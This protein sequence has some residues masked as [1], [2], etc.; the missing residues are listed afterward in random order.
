MRVSRPRPPDECSGDE[1]RAD[2]CPEERVGVQR[3]RF[4]EEV[5]GLKQEVEERR[6]EEG[7][8]N[9]RDKERYGRDE[10]HGEDDHERDRMEKRVRVEREIPPREP[11][12]PEPAG[13]PDEACKPPRNK[14]AEEEKRNL[15][16]QGKV[17]RL[18]IDLLGLEHP[19]RQDRYGAEPPRRNSRK[20]GHHDQE[21][22]DGDPP[23]QRVPGSGEIN[24]HG[25][26][27]EG[28]HI[29]RRGEERSRFP[30]AD[31]PPEGR[32]QEDEAEESD[33]QF[34]CVAVEIFT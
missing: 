6:R 10:D 16:G 28:R 1:E 3:D 8:R 24:K 20:P 15:C 11:S 7:G 21:P 31:L 33:Q 25:K 32:N 13:E 29:E 12:P 9:P 26:D 19:G 5:S 34:G 30:P 17:D 22:E 27:D 2:E 18:W 4:R 23:E 14:D